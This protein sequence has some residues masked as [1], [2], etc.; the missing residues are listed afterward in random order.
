M[1]V[2]DMDSFPLRIANV[3][4][5]KDIAVE[6]KENIYKTCTDLCSMRPLLPAKELALNRYRKYGFLVLQK[7]KRELLKIYLI[8]SEEKVIN[9]LHFFLFVCHVASFNSRIKSTLTT[10]STS[11][12]AQR[13]HS[14]TIHM[15]R[16]QPIFCKL[17]VSLLRSMAGRSQKKSFLSIR[18]RVRKEI[19]TYIERWTWQRM[20]PWKC[21]L[22]KIRKKKDLFESLDGYFC[23][24]RR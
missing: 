16:P 24:C 10:P 14:D 13:S 15:L 18:P 6:C 5:F 23:S 2:A 9:S 21:M 7:K 12:W 17:F 19:T 3:V 4:N 11:V 1:I 8:S 20:W 22:T